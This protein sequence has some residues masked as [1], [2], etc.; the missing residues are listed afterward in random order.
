MKKVKVDKKS[1]LVSLKESSLKLDPKKKD[2]KK[3]EQDAD[4]LPDFSIKDL[5][6]S[7]TS[8]TI[9]SFS[10]GWQSEQGKKLP[11]V[12]DLH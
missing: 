7:G 5:S 12:S 6:I 4:T 3:L 10:T 11:M 2:D 9:I 8:T 1:T